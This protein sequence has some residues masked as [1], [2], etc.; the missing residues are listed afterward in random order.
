MR[1]VGDWR[2]ISEGEFAAF[3]T[4]RSEELRERAYVAVEAQVARQRAEAGVEH[5]DRAFRETFLRDIPLGLIELRDAFSVNGT[6]GR[7]LRDR[8][9]MVRINGVVFVH[10]GITPA[11]AAMGC[12][13]I[14]AEVQDEIA[15]TMPTLEQL[16]NQLSSSETGPLWDRS[17]VME[18]EATY[19][20]TAERV[21]NQLEARAMVLG[22]TP[23][24]DGLV[25]TRFGGRVIQID[26]GMLNGEFFPNGQPAA[27]EIQDDQL[28]AIYLDERDALGTLPLDVP[29][30]ADVPEPLEPPSAQQE[31]QSPD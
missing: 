17:L 30:P 28:N 7:W 5:D 26:T 16:P 14:N 15:G 4:L 6:Y 19:R 3:R 1:L 27:L 20:A 18:P 2:Y 11:V 22:H 24:P 10:G 21:L 29:E 8:P 31:E 25:M 9:T 12:G 23:V 13:P